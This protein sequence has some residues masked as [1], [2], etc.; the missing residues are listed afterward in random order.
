MQ[1]G[2]NFF[3]ML[4]AGIYIH[5]MGWVLSHWGGGGQTGPEGYQ[6]AFFLAFAGV[7]AATVLYAFTKE[8]KW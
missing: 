3:T 8:A 7:A 4:G 5:A 1:A 2:I 6:A